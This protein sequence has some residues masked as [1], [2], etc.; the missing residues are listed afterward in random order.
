[1]HE[2]LTR[3]CDPEDVRP[4]C[5]EPFEVKGWSVAINGARMLVWHEHGGYRS[6]QAVGMSVSSVA[7]F[8]EHGHRGAS[9]EYQ[10]YRVSAPRFRDFCGTPRALLDADCPAAPTWARFGWP[11]VDRRLL[12]D[13]VPDLPGETFTFQVAGPSDPVVIWGTGWHLSVMGVAV[14]RIAQPLQDEFD[15]ATFDLEGDSAH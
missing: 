10:D 4:F 8:V 3:I 9:Q 11:I 1:M 15:I 6:A 12:A 13:I 14:G 7:P 5:R 2:L